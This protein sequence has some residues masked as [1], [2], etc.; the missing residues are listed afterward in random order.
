MASKLHLIT[1]GC[2]MNEYDS[3]RVAGLLRECQYELTADEHEADVILLN[4]CAI[5]EK[6]EE[7]VFSKLGELK[8]LKARRPD[9]VIGVMGCMAQLQQEQ[10]L[11]RAPAVD[12]VFG[13][14]AIARVGEL[15]ERARR[16]RRPVLET[17]EAPLVKI[18]AKPPRAD[19]LKAFVTV[20]E[21]CE[22]HC[23][24]CVVPRTRGRER[25]HTPES[26]LA[27]IEGLVAEGCREVTLLGQTVNAYGR[28]LTPPTDLAELFARVNDVE[29]LA[30]IRFTTSN[31]YN[32]TPKLIRAMRDVPKVCEWFH[33]PLQSG[34]DRVLERMN[35]GYTRA[36]YLELVDALREVEPA[37][38]FSTDI[39]VGFP[40]ETEDDFEATVE[41]I[42]RVRYDNVFVFRYSPRP[43][44]P[45]AAMPEQIPDGVKASR[46]SRLL[47]VVQR[48]AAERSR[49]L[50]GR[51]MEV[52]VD[53][54]SRKNP[55]E[56]S[57][58]TRCNRVVN[59][60]GQGEIGLGDLVQIR[61][62]DVLPHSLRGALATPEEAVCWSR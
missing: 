45:A 37:M 8:R 10:V 2:Q 9:L 6:A 59:F 52:L 4:T 39:I 11:R 22:K 21:G 38:A 5:R 50:A 53:G 49:L 34:S 46:N 23:T 25:S 36:R 13:S 16:E 30:R 31:P 20:M 61:V 43:G 35:R 58:R 32:L 14:P 55:G 15:V 51:T 33:L 3:E 54:T 12:L 7:K 29:G 1:Y 48:V 27:E 44:T 41:M 62:T 17:A 19:R 47:E 40:G 18:T 28:D 60:D 24:F 26:I 42:E 57:G 56:L